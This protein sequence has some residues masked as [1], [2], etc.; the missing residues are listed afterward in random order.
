ME[1]SSLRQRRTN[2]CKR[3]KEENR[4]TEHGTKGQRERRTEKTD[5]RKTQEVERE[6]RRW[7]GIVAATKSKSWKARKVLCYTVFYWFLLL[8]EAKYSTICSKLPYKVF[9]ILFKYSVCTVY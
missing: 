4:G 2:Q 9:Q 3:R 1:A 8:G 5:R 7:R 6:G